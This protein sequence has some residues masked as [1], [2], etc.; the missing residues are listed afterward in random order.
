MPIA[1]PPGTATGHLPDPPCTY[2]RT[3]H[4]H[5]RGPPCTHARTPMHARAGHPVAD[6]R[7]TPALIAGVPV[8]CFSGEGRCTTHPPP[9]VSRGQAGRSGASGASLVWEAGVRSSARCGPSQGLIHIPASGAPARRGRTWEDTPGVTG[10]GTVV[11]PRAA[12]MIS[13]GA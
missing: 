3:P 6:L 2:T 11:H 10:R 4:A 9:P 12:L 5:E 7:D 1:V 13:A 8:P